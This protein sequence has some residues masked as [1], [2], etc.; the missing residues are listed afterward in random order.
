MAY[1]RKSA[2]GL[3]VGLLVNCTNPS[4]LAYYLS[5][6]ENGM[7]RR[8]GVSHRCL[9]R[10]DEGRTSAIPAIHPN[11]NLISHERLER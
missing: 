9:R 1:G 10:T 2:Y 5:R 7:I 8:G 6:T 3:E 11:V 4:I